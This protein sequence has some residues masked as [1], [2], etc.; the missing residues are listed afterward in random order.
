M[1]KKSLLRKLQNAEIT[2]IEHKFR[3]HFG[4]TSTG[5]NGKLSITFLKAILRQQLQILSV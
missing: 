4:D 3:V 2:P 5:V 1:G